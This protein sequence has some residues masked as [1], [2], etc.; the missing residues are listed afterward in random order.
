MIFCC[1]CHW[2]FLP[3]AYA[4]SLLESIWRRTLCEVDHLALVMELTQLF[5]RRMNSFQSHQAFWE[6]FRCTKEQ[7]IPMLLATHFSYH[8]MK[9]CIYKARCFF[10]S[11]ASLPY[12]IVS[13]TCNRLL[14]RALFHWDYAFYLKRHKN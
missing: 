4:K 6:L 14:E 5:S 9:C 2:C 12:C 1:F 13:I 10:S 7:S 11:F 8:V 3:L